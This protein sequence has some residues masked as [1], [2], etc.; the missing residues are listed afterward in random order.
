MI[1]KINTFPD[2]ILNVKAKECFPV[3]STAPGALLGAVVSEQEKQLW[4]EEVIELAQNLVDTA[5]SLGKECAGLASNQIWDKDEE[6]LAMFVVKYELPQTP[7]DIENKTI[8]HTWAEFI[9]P[10]IQTSGKSIDLKEQ[11]FSLPGKTSRTKRKHNVTITFQTIAN[12]EPVTTKFFL[13]DSFLP[14][15]IQHEYD[16]LMGKLI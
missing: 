16:H 7:E 2:K 5:N 10:K 12:I 3:A 1:K 4:P 6:P 15:V 13:K 14:I 9:N 11:C 8:R